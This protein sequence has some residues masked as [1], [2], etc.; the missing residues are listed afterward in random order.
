VFAAHLSTMM[1]ISRMSV[2]F[3]LFDNTPISARATEQ[4]K[5][6]S[7]DTLAAQFRNTK[8][9]HF[10]GYEKDDSSKVA[11]DEQDDP[12]WTTRDIVSKSVPMCNVF[13]VHLVET[14]RAMK[15]EN[16][17]DENREQKIKFEKHR[18]WAL[19][20]ESAWQF[21]VSPWPPTEKD[22]NTD[23]R[24]N[25]FDAWRKV[26]PDLSNESL[27]MYWWSNRDPSPKNPETLKID[28]KNMSDTSKYVSQEN[29]DGHLLIEV[30]YARFH[31]RIYDTLRYIK[32]IHNAFQ[33]YCAIAQEPD[34]VTN[35]EIYDSNVLH[36][37]CRKLKK[38]CKFVYAR[39]DQDKKWYNMKRRVVLDQMWRLAT[40]KKN[41]PE[42][43]EALDKEIDLTILTTSAAS[44]EQMQATE[45]WKT[46]VLQLYHNYR[47]DPHR[48]LK[49]YT[50]SFSVV[51]GSRVSFIKDM[52][53]S[54]ICYFDFSVHLRIA[55]STPLNALEKWPLNALE[56]WAPDGEIPNQ[57]LKE[58]MRNF[59]KPY[60][61]RTPDNSTPFFSNS[62]SDDSKNLLSLCQTYKNEMNKAQ[63][64]RFDC[65][66]QKFHDIEHRRRKI[67]KKTEG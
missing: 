21:F 6:L 42:E 50:G 46:H 2:R 55:L 27:Q 64:R 49:H 39:L 28:L 33:F 47:A 34:F 25:S 66:F 61:F 7:A 12:A 5:L 13:F 57:L 44:V 9:C 38:L 60:Q 51:T 62:S 40:A 36:Q 8:L 16:Q 19:T 1:T 67:Q 4:S 45:S 63:I 30:W 53:K 48:R 52:E 11:G 37:Q 31:R 56:K 14:I 23:A 26:V 18:D 22:S 35:H 15:P 54:D 65:F 29:K 20:I 3:P 43:L 41:S 32:Q 59:F 58:E 17:S 24:F 10:A